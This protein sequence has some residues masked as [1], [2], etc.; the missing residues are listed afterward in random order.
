MRRTRSDT[1]PAARGGLV[2]ALHDS[3][4][5]H[6]ISD[7]PRPG[8][9]WT[10]ASLAEEMAMLRSAFAARFTELVGSPR[11][12]TSRRWRMQVAVDAHKQEGPTSPSW[13]QPRLLLVLSNQVFEDRQ[14]KLFNALDHFEGV[15]GQL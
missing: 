2:G 15:R 8:C 10:A 9:P 11:C 3:Q 5:G 14:R 6:A 12:S 7:P 4:I 13:R 1:D